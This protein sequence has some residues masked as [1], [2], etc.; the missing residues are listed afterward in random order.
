MCS[1]DGT[2]ITRGSTASTYR[3]AL[4][5]VTGSDFALSGRMSCAWGPPGLETPTSVPG[6]RRIVVVAGF[7]L[8]LAIGIPWCH[9]NVGH[10][11]LLTGNRACG[12]APSEV[13]VWAFNHHTRQPDEAVNLQKWIARNR[14]RINKQYGAFCDPPLHFAARFG[15]EDLADPLIAGG[16][17]IEGRNELDERPLHAAAKYGHGAVVKLLLARGADVNATARSGKTALHFAAFGLGTQSNVEARIR[18]AKQLLAAGADVNARE[19]GS[20]F[21]PLRYATSYESRNQAMADLLLAHGA[22]PRGAEE[23]PTPSATRAR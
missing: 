4:D 11:D 13:R 21:T 19:Q 22:D 16:A 5:R 14:G 12:A 20:G 8:V 9:E 6:A 3:T 10:V 2:V 7:C 17:D 23:P 15:R 18:V 1:H